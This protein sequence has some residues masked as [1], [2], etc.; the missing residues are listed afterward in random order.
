[1]VDIY[2]KC[3]WCQKTV[4]HKHIE[5]G[6]YVFGNY[7]RSKKLQ[8][9]ELQGKDSYVCEDCYNV[10]QNK[11]EHLRACSEQENI[12]KVSRRTERCEKPADV[13][14]VEYNDYIPEISKTHSTSK[15]YQDSGVTITC[16]NK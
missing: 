12:P 13:T 1:M 5:K 11:V 7:D 3:D 15:D 16:E 10:I 4:E 8:R 9:I 14:Y 2:F 6:H